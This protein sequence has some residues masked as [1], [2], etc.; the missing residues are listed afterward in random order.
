MFHPFQ[1]FGL[2]RVDGSAV[3]QAGKF[4]TAFLQPLKRS[5]QIVEF[6]DQIVAVRSFGIWIAVMQPEAQ[7][8]VC[9]LCETQRD[10]RDF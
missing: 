7:R 1:N 2:L 9:G 5:H 10:L 4:D 6:T 3:E 8:L